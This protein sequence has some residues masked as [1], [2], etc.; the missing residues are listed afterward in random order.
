MEVLVF[1]IKGDFGHFRK[2]YTTSSP[3]TFAFPPPPTV[4]GML[5]AVAGIDKT[6]YLASF[7]HANCSLAVALDG[8]VKKMRL[9]LNHINTKND[10]WVP[11]K[12]GAHEARTQIRTE[13]LKD[14]CYTIYVAHKD[15]ELFNSL[16]QNI[17]EHKTVFTLSL[18]LSELLADFSFV[19]TFEFHQKQEV[20]KEVHTVIPM[21][22]IAPS[23]IVFE[24][25]K[26]YFKEKVPVEMTPERIVERYEEVLFEAQGK[27]LKVRLKEC[28]E[29]ED[30]RC[31]TFF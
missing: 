30:G 24:G 13:L 20:V 10:Y 17:K 23:G 26:K 16:A 6:E 3:L 28:W 25:E 19:G 29:G 21:S 7:S 2:Y 11:V 31:I 18:G 1:Q 8:P 14:P 4:K 15:K 22:L 27:P 9:A 12:K 5:A